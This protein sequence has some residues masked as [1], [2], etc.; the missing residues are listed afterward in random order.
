LFSRN[1]SQDSLL[2]QQ[3]EDTIQGRTKKRG[4]CFQETQLSYVYINQGIHS[5]LCNLNELQCKVIF[6]HKV[7]R[8]AIVIWKC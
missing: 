6:T 7:Y 5:G 3:T 8:G 1:S 2:S 4:I